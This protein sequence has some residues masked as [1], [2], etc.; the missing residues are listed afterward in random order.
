MKINVYCRNL[1]WLF[2]DLKQ[3]IAKHGAIASETPLPDMDAYICIRTKESA[4][5]PK[6][7][8]TVVQVHD[9][10]NYV[11]TR[12]GMAAMVH[13]AQRVLADNKIMIPIGSRD[14]PFLPAP[15]RPTLGFFCREVGKNRVKG[16]DLFAEAVTIARKHMNFDVLMIGANL[17]HISKIG[18]YEKRAATPDDYARISAYCTTSKSPMIPLSAY[19]AL[20]AGRRV[21]TTPREWPHPFEG[22]HTGKTAKEMAYCIV[23]ALNGGIIEKQKPWS[24]DDWCKRMVDEARKLCVQK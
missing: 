7:E 16:S 13:P 8:K 23:E 5:S 3:N 11:L 14:I 15:E 22:I 21:V 9:M 20:T 19:E 12:F 1:G 6:S 4:L 24:R 10:M 17:E 18:K 2:E